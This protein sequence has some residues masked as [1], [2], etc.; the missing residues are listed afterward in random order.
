MDRVDR[1]WDSWPSLRNV[2]LCRGEQNVSDEFLLK[3]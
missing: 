3:A 2:N 1:W